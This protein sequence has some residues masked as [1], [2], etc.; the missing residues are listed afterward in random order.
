[1]GG[2]L[3]NLAVELFNRLVQSLVFGRAQVSLLILDRLVNGIQLVKDLLARLLRTGLL[4][5]D[6]LEFVA[7]RSTLVITLA[8]ALL[9]ANLVAYRCLS[10]IHSCQPQL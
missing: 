1:M 10:S 3:P 9:A 8:V 4:V 5:T 2:A 6:L 7:Q